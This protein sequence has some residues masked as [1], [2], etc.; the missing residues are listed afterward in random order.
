MFEGSSHS[1]TPTTTP[2][3]H[4]QQPLL[5]TYASD[6]NRSSSTDKGS[7]D[8]KPC[9]V[10]IALMRLCFSSKSIFNDSG[11]NS[12]IFWQCKYRPYSKTACRTVVN[13][14][15]VVQ[16]PVVEKERMGQKKRQKKRQKKG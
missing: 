13:T 14:S 5:P 4:T 2:N 15:S 16:V 11:S 10:R 8:G 3:N 9:R 1:Y 12:F 7:I 6:N